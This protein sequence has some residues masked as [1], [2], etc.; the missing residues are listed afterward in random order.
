MN[1]KH[2]TPAPENPGKLIAVTGA[3]GK[4]GGA[5]LRHLAKG[6]FR[7]RGITRNLKGAAAVALLGQG[8]EMAEAD[9]DRPETLGPALAGAHGVFSVQNFYGKGVGF[10]G[11]IRQGRHLAVASK[12]A[13]VAHFVQ[14][15]MATAEGAGDVRHFQS[16]FAIEGIVD[17]LGLPRTFLGTVWFMDNLFDKKLGG[18]MN[19][20]FVR[21]FLGKGRAFEMMAVDDL[22]GTAAAVFQSPAAFIGRKI[23]I[24]GDRMSWEKMVS[25]FASII[26]RNPPRFAL[27][28]FLA[29]WLHRDFASQLRWHARNG[30][31]FPL[32]ECRAVYPQMQDFSTFLKRNASRFRKKPRGMATQ[33]I[34]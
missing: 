34:G 20:P 29:T 9:L 19:F 23:D 30:W 5:V 13:G 25:T 26:G 22:G 21:G 32:A 33:Q 16:K 15:T 24:A 2:S 27:P 14:S 8:Y 4:Q 7:V 1:G 11:E 31:S 18:E 17:E 3:T 10:D 12:E 6:G 28:R